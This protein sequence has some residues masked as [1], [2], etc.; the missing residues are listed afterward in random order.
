MKDW[1]A[2]VQP[3]LAGPIENEADAPSGPPHATCDCAIECNVKVPV[4]AVRGEVS[5]LRRAGIAYELWE[6][7]GPHVFRSN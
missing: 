2:F 7:D 3:P 6:I 4:L 1:S 5:R